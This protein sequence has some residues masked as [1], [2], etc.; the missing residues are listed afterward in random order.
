VTLQPRTS[1]CFHVQSS[2]RRRQFQHNRITHTHTYTH[3]IIQRGEA[4]FEQRLPYF[5]KARRYT[6]THTHT[7]QRTPT[8]H[9]HTVHH[10]LLHQH[11]ATHPNTTSIRFDGRQL[12]EIEQAVQ[13][14]TPIDPP[15]YHPIIIFIH[16]IQHHIHSSI[17]PER[18]STPFT[19]HGLATQCITPFQSSHAHQSLH[20]IRLPVSTLLFR[21]TESREAG[22]E[23]KKDERGKGQEKGGAKR[24]INANGKQKGEEKTG[25]LD[26]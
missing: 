12:G 24:W 9:Q 8:P 6:H 18:S 5:R 22:K 20:S 10:S 25:G 16:F 19:P 1:V 13:R 11:R 26:R 21:L 3:H 7:H 4:S 2:R 17:T 14:Y 15:K 23:R